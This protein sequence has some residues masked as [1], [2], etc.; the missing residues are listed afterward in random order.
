MEETGCLSHINAHIKGK[1]ERPSDTLF[2]GYQ[3]LVTLHAQKR[4]V[5]TMREEGTLILISEQK[6]KGTK[7]EYAAE[8]R[9]WQG[10]QR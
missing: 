4:A 3:D 10:G 6:G 5:K 8:V 2:E 7:Q 1:K 9:K